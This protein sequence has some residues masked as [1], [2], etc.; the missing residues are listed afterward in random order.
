MH[1]HAVDPFEPFDPFH[2]R[3]A[4]L[5]HIYVCDAL[6]RDGFGSTS[7]HIHLLLR[8]G[9]CCLLRCLTTRSVMRCMCSRLLGIAGSFRH[10]RFGSPLIFTISLLSMFD[11]QTL[12]TRPMRSIGL[13][14]LAALGPLAKAALRQRS[15]QQNCANRML[16]ITGGSSQNLAT[17]FRDAVRL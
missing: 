11:R 2:F 8:W 9:C 13:F 7:T 12:C 14:F 17:F 15:G 10:V 5:H 16:L 4:P 1:V 6:R 3:D